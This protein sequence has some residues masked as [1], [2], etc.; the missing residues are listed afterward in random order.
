MPLASLPTPSEM[1]TH[2]DTRVRGQRQAK[3]DLAVAFYEHY[4]GLASGEAPELGG[5][6]HARQHLLLLGPSGCGKTY[7]VKTLCAHLRI[8]MAFWSATSISGSGHAGGD[9]GGEGGRGRRGGLGRA[10]RV[11]CDVRRGGAGARSR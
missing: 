1:M 8:P 4:S 11:L 7:L 10:G 5:P 2:L 9:G 6:S 3:R